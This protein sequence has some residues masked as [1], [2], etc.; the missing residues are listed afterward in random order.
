MKPSRTCYNARNCCGWSKLFCRIYWSRWRFHR[1]GSKKEGQKVKSHPLQHLLHDSS[2]FKSKGFLMSNS[3]LF[4][5]SW[6][7][8]EMPQFR[9]CTCHSEAKNPNAA[10]LQ[11]PERQPWILSAATGYT[12]E[13][14]RH[15]EQCSTGWEKQHYSPTKGHS[16]A[17][18]VLQRRD[19][20]GKNQVSELWNEEKTQHHYP[21]NEGEHPQQYSKRNGKVR[22]R[23]RHSN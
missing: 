5:P 11:S 12:E 22:K 8:T 16:A 13:V 1:G 15:Q 23:Q 20:H 21:E 18:L 2:T 17:R 14:H 7:R 9:S 10:L 3:L 6:N 4:W 19:C